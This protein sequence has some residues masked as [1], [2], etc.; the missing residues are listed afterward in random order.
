MAEEHK[1]GQ[2][3]QT[4]ATLDPSIDVGREEVA[5]LTKLAATAAETV[6]KK[7]KKTGSFW[8]SKISRKDKGK[9]KKLAAK[10]KEAK[11]QED[12]KKA[13]AKVA[14]EKLEAEKKAQE[15]HGKET[16][17]AKVYE[18]DK[19]KLQLKINIYIEEINA[20]DKGFTNKLNTSPDQT[21]S[22]LISTDPEDG[23][24]LNSLKI[25][26]RECL[27]KLGSVM[28]LRE[29]T[30]VQRISDYINNLKETNDIFKINQ[31]LTEDNK[32]D[33]TIDF[34]DKKCDSQDSIDECQTKLTQALELFETFKGKMQNAYEYQGTNEGQ[35]KKLGKDVDNFK[36][37]FEKWM[38]QLDQL[39]DDPITE[40]KTLKGTIQGYEVNQDLLGDEKDLKKN[41]VKEI[42]I[43]IN[44]ITEYKKY[45]DELKEAKK[46]REQAQAK[47]EA[48]KK[49]ETSAQVDEAA[50][51]EEQ[52]ELEEFGLKGDGDGQPVVAKTEPVEGGPVVTHTGI[53]EDEAYQGK[54]VSTEEGAL[55]KDEQNIE[56]LKEGEAEHDRRVRMQE[57]MLPASQKKLAKSLSEGYIKDT[58][59]PPLERSE[60]ASATTPLMEES[61]VQKGIQ[62]IEGIKK[63]PDEIERETA[64]KKRESLEQEAK[65]KGALVESLPQVPPTPSAGMLEKPE[66]KATATSD[67]TTD[68]P[69]TATSDGT[70]DEPSVATIGGRK[71]KSRRRKKSKKRKS[72]KNRR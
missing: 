27:K 31:Y 19:A 25:K 3:L 35:F 37:E 29:S 30:Q 64:A 26:L 53:D 70:T 10:E 47:L 48:L 33:E 46:N 72:K 45:E 11:E 65:I 51:E 15:I 8:P 14:A 32:L 62:K 39:V 38:G 68:E 18:E 43:L 9:L 23:N 66:V 1:M 60:S 5:D 49:V 54:K 55:V 63:K 50:K 16:L 28:N 42:D 44:T 13:A 36:K 41:M 6:P 20:L 17:N 71:K 40:L 2:D 56:S 58:K 69:A 34:E 22:E 57:K 52:E 61:Q 59:P 7:K 12:A 4:E 21:I 24:T 67:G